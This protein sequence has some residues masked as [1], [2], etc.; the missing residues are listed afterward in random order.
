MKN[1]K[2][3]WKMLPLMAA[4][5]LTGMMMTGCDASYVNA[6]RDLE[7]ALNPEDG[8]YLTVDDL[9]LRFKSDS[10]SLWDK[11]R[12]VGTLV[13]LPLTKEDTRPKEGVS[14]VGNGSGSTMTFDL[15]S[16]ADMMAR[17]LGKVYV[18]WHEDSWGLTA[19]VYK[20]SE[21]FLEMDTC[22]V[23]S[24]GRG[25]YTLYNDY[26]RQGMLLFVYPGA[27]SILV[28]RG[29]EETQRIFRLN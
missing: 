6:Q 19:D 17:T 15:S 21:P 8:S 5:V 10:I 27:D 29:S 9:L 1:M 23:E 25:V 4:G 3:T 24:R 11:M 20:F 14:Y 22:Y 2:K 16:S 18:E 12:G 28:H 13:E 7:R 26:G